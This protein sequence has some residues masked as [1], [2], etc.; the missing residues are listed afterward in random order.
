MTLLSPSTLPTRGVLTISGIVKNE[1][2]DSWTDVNVAPFLSSEPITTRDELAEAAASA[3]DTFSGNRLT[4][5]STQVLVGDLAPGKAATFTVRVHAAALAPRDPGVY[6]IGVHA[7]G[8]GP[9]GRDLEADGR[10]RTFLPFVP[11][12]AARLRTVPLSVVLPVRDRARRAAD[13]SL[14]GPTRWVHLTAP[15]GRLSRLADFGASAGDVPLTWVV[16]PAVLDALKDFGQGN[17]P[18]SLGPDR[19]A[20]QANDKKDDQQPDSSPSPSPSPSTGP[21]APSEQERDRANLVLNTLQLTIRSHPAL[22][23]GY[24]DPDVASLARR[25]PNLLRRSEELSASSMKAHELTGSAVVAPP[26][27]YF[28]PDLLGRLPAST[29]MLLSDH[30]ELA[31]PPLSK[32][33]TGQDLVLTDERAVTGGPLPNPPRTPLALRQRL[34]SEAA[35]EVT[36]E[37]TPVRPVVFS[38]PASW[39]PGRYWRDADFFGGLEVPWLRLTSLPRGASTPYDGELPYG[40]TQL[41]DEIGP[42][43]VAATRGLVHTSTVLGHLLAND[44]D[45]TDRLDGAALQASAYSAKPTPGLAADQVRAL[46]DSTRAEMARVQVTGTD[47]VTLSGGSGSLTV[48]LVNGLKQPITV[49][50]RA[51]SDSSE[52]K[53]QTPEPVSM[54]AGERTTM[55]LRVSSGVG[56]H[57][58]TLSPVTTKGENAGTPLTF[59]LRTSQV[60]RLIWYIIIAGG[61][62][63]AVMIVRRIVLRIRLNRWRVDEE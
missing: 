12:S 1:S 47:F 32:L 7:L 30:G 56:V 31:D 20:G 11:K 15:E 5:P 16:D 43:N 53:V 19:R 6:W 29:L 59:G 2:K 63:L 41:A 61:V 40:R 58:V 18:L 21:D 50:L 38:F 60:G 34:L 14:N 25:G 35:L 27:G 45:V 8:T 52:V 13:G 46:D 9:D 37:G 10:A 51:R 23:L 3:P 54:Q 24:A 39:N 44:N 62:L 26:E 42:T 49:G 4:D 28:D 48:T 22:A 36:K 55:R 33:P 17:P 57:E